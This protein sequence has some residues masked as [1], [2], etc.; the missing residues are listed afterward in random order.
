MPNSLLNNRLDVVKWICTLAG[1]IGS[2]VPGATFFNS[3]APPVFE[4]VS[5]L[6]GGAALAIILYILSER[7][8]KRTSTARSL[9]FIFIGLLLIVIYGFARNYYT[10]GTPPGWG[11]N[12]IQ[13]GFY[14]SKWSMT[15]KA[16]DYLAQDPG[17]TPERLM[18]AFA[19]YEEHGVE[20]IWK[21]W[22]VIAAGSILIILFSGGFLFWTAGFALLG[23]SLSKESRRK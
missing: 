9:S 16:I 23:R 10:A 7:S 8:K 20:K 6:T 11:G 19:A 4:A 21:P 2:V 15:D 18:F 17:V 14:L 12:R 1:G 13:I 22:S 5:L 3:Y